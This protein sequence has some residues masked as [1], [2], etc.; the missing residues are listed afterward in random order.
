MAIKNF[1]TPIPQTP[2]SKEQIRIPSP[3]L[4]TPEKLLNNVVVG[5]I[6]DAKSQIMRG[7]AVVNESDEQLR[8][9]QLGTPIYT[10]V[11]IKKTS[12]TTVTSG[13]FSG[14]G[15]LRFDSCIVTIN[16]QRNIIKT[17]IQGRNGT[18][19]EYISDG[20]YSISLKGSIFGDRPDKAPN[21]I[22]N[23]IYNLFVEPNELWIESNFIQYF[24]VQYVVIE[25]Y[26]ITQVEGSRSRIDIDIQMISDLPIELELGIK[27]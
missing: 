21:Q 3:A 5:K 17:P 1:N 8:R 25:N 7:N 12:D 15:F 23:D 9:S 18:V 2:L 6:S 26:T 11:V 24:G 22:M 19:K 13:Q 4:P 14:N 20:D 27:E 16:Q 10:E